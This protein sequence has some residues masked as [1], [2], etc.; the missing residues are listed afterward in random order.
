MKSI[1]APIFEELVASHRSQLKSFLYRFTASREDAEDLSQETFIKAFK[2][3]HT[4]KGEST[5]KTWL[6][7][8][9]TNL[10]KDHLRAKKRWPTNAQDMCKDLIGTT[11]ESGAELRHIAL[12]SEAGK[13]EIKEHIDFCF[14]CIMK[15]LPLEQHLALMLADIYSFK[16]K[17]IASIMNLT[18]G[19]IKHHLHNSRGTMQNVFEH[20]CALINKN[21]TCHQCSE[22]N[23]FRN[24]K[25]E[26]Q[27]IIAEMELV[28]AATQNDK[29]YLFQ[30][31]TELVKAIDP[32]Q[33]S[34]TDLH[35][36]LLKQT[37]V[38]IDKR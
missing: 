2:N 8:I 29:T 19:V 33:A 14:T 17:E 25:A 28:K 22:L 9:A 36:F 32:L 23:G 7:A 12:T 38:A 30:I 3:Y 34:S 20:R 27:R 37:A 31:R 5:F 26:T 1:A 18:Q 15:T 16:I 24:T 4:F 11:P 35:D 21:G 6:F 13:Y 10:A